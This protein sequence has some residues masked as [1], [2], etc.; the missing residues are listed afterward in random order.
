MTE[1]TQA[2]EDNQDERLTNLERYVA[3]LLIDVDIIKMML[4]ILTEGTK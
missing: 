3:Q 4:K 1:N 2:H